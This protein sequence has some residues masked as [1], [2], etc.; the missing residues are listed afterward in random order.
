MQAH[1]PCTPPRIEVCVTVME[2]HV[3]RAVGT[4]QE[5]AVWIARL[6]PLLEVISK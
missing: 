2:T 5:S 4:V 1:S 3:Q 6:C